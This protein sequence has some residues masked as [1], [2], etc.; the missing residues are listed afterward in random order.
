MKTACISKNI[1][2]NTPEKKD[3]NLKTSL[4]EDIRSLLRQAVN[5]SKRQAFIEEKQKSNSMK[6]Q[7]PFERRLLPSQNKSDIW[8]V[9]MNEVES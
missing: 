4:K 7:D 6:Y 5:Q 1:R 2:L 3:S 8:F 9:T